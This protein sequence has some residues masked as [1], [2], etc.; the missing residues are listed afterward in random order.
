[1]K[2]PIVGWNE[3]CI[4]KV[5]LPTFV[6]HFLSLFYSSFYGLFLYNIFFCL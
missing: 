1:M 5:V 2:I 6:S 4:A 3:M